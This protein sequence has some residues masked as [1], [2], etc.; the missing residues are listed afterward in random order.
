MNHGAL[1][2]VLLSG[3]SPVNKLTTVKTISA[4]SAWVMSLAVFNELGS[5]NK[6]Q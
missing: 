6:T 3:S 4:N 2:L 5:K 1:E